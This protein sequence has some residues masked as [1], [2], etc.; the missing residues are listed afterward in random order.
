MIKKDSIGLKLRPILAAEDIFTCGDNGIP[1]AQTEPTYWEKQFVADNSV[2]DRY[3]QLSLHCY[4]LHSSGL[5]FWHSLQVMFGP[6]ERPVETIEMI[7]VDRY[8]ADCLHVV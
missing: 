4:D 5:L 3:P 2:G 1:I 6:T 7:I 8:Y